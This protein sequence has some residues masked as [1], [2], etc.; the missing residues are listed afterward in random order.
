[1]LLTGIGAGKY[2]S[3]GDIIIESGTIIARAGDSFQNS[4]A[5]IGGQCGNITISGGTITAYGAYE[6]AG[7]GSGWD[8]YC[9]D[10]TILGGTITATKGNTAINSIGVGYSNGDCGTVT[11]K[12]G[13][14]VNNKTYTQDETGPVQ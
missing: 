10:I 1:M 3:C 5:G 6:G 13:A 14:T 8:T 7:I 9:G 12:A 11:I 4:S 2:A